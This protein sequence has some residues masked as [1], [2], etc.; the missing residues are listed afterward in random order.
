MSSPSIVF[1]H[2]LRCTKVPRAPAAS[3]SS[4]SSITQTSTLSTPT[5]LIHMVQPVTS[6]VDPASTAS[7]SSG[8]ITTSTTTTL[9]STET[10][11]S[12]RLSS[13]HVSSQPQ[14][15]T[16]ITLLQHAHT[17]RPS[18]STP[19]ST[20]T[21]ETASDSHPTHLSAN[22][23]PTGTDDTLRTVLASIFSAL[24]FLALVF[25]I[26]Y[27]ISRR[28]KRDSQRHSAQGAN[29]RLLHSTRESADSTISSQH[30]QSQ[31]LSP[32]SFTADS[33]FADTSTV[34]REPSWFLAAFATPAPHQNA[35]R[36]QQQQQPTRDTLIPEHHNQGAAQTTPQTSPY[37]NPSLS[38]EQSLG[39]TIIL[40]GRSSLA[41]SNYFPRE[42]YYPEPGLSESESR[43]R[44]SMRSDPFDLERPASVLRR[45]DKRE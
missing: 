43:V 38:S 25:L 28:R 31:Y 44:Y 23:Q 5:A 2:G 6:T 10:R 42:S 24:V 12:S 17:T 14:P 4:S 34:H 35:S 22:Q 7:V 11:R 18:S 26:Y 16:S 20:L 3:T 21:H 13:A 8:V 37:L 40:P 15:G 36:D 45:G 32:V 33:P 1:Y 30:H 9:S 41:S 29:Q 39:S 27:L 19:H